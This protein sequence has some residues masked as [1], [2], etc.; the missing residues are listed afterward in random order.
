MILLTSSGSG[1]ST[2]K[3]R[4]TRVSP[5]YAPSPSPSPSPLLIPRAVPPVPTSSSSCADKEFDVVKKNDT[6]SVDDSNINRSSRA[7]ASP[8]TAAAA[9]SAADAF[10]SMDV[11]QG[12]EGPL[13]ATINTE[14][15]AACSISYNT[16]VDTNDVTE[17]DI[18]DDEDDV[19][20]KNRAANDKNECHPSSILSTVS[21]P[22]KSTKATSLLLPMS[23]ILAARSQGTVRTAYH[24]N[25]GRPRTER[26][27]RGIWTDDNVVV[28]QDNICEDRNHRNDYV[29]NDV[30]N[31]RSQNQA[32][33]QQNPNNKS[34][35]KKNHSH[36]EKLRDETLI[37]I[38][39]FLDLADLLRSGM[40]CRRWS[41]QV[42]Y[43]SSLWKCVDA[44]AFVRCAYRTFLRQLL[45][46][47]MAI[48]DDDVVAQTTTIT[49]Q[50]SVYRDCPSL[51][52]SPSPFPSSSTINNTRKISKNAAHSSPSLST[53]TKRAQRLTGSCLE[54]ILQNRK[55]ESLVIKGI[56][57]VLDANHFHLPSLVLSS[58]QELTLSHFNSLSDTHLHVLLLMTLGGEN[59]GPG[60]GV[61]LKQK[62]RNKGRS[63]NSLRVLALEHCK[64]LTD[65]SLASI[66]K[67]CGDLV[68]LSLRGNTNITDVSPLQ[69]LFATK[70]RVAEDHRKGSSSVLTHESN[71]QRDT[72]VS[73][74]VKQGTRHELKPPSLMLTK[75][76][77]QAPN[78][79]RTFQTKSPPPLASFFVPPQ[80][81]NDLVKIETNSSTSLH[82]IKQQNA[83]SEKSCKSAATTSPLTHQSSNTSIRQPPSHTGTDGIQTSKQQMHLLFSPPPTNKPLPS[84]TN[85]MSSLFTPPPTTKKP[86]SHS[87][88]Q[89]S[90]T[91]CSSSTFNTPSTSSNISPLVDSTSGLTNLFNT[92]GSSPPRKPRSFRGVDS[93]LFAVPGMDRPNTDTNVGPSVGMRR[94]QRHQRSLLNSTSSLSSSSSAH[95]NTVVGTLNRLDLTQTGVTA[96]KIVRCFL[97]LISFSSHRTSNEISPTDQWGWVCL[98]ELFLCPSNE[99][100][101][102]DI[103]A[104]PLHVELLILEKVLLMD[105]IDE[106]HVG[107]ES[108]DSMATLVSKGQRNSR[109]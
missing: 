73:L 76:Q 50:S 101:Y 39:S 13:T 6:F 55:P 97:D 108:G 42:R 54:S 49:Q 61:V 44:S 29:N 9:A 20:C 7:A 105:E 70:E 5:D 88:E 37:T 48:T 71:E 86:V 12:D 41:Y 103:E 80:P 79:A 35:A 18:G 46:Q 81:K 98:K 74:R 11:L 62:R 78:F 85:S 21:A 19:V 14:H 90:T 26:R 30:I 60:A 95:G 45:Q 40:V 57:D 92:P 53:L 22:S 17:N 66:A 59:P 106:L 4:K 15:L 58:L 28:I 94:Y 87:F 52:P 67:T 100:P 75:S 69:D 31:N 47:E 3:N 96:Q 56:H 2:K 63:Q 38:M 27:V 25:V 77:H 1:G 65:S 99:S 72:F 104:S 68:S 33:S 8:P 82:E 89:S 83:K 43:E 16:N 91:I 36:F 84:P 107:A 109:I 23:S 24:R 64:L 93:S 32:S 102:V 51:S 10:V 34:I